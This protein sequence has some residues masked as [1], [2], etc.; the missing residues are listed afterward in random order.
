MIA[1]VIKGLDNPFFATMRDGVVATARA[2]NVQLS[3]AAAGGLEDTAGQASAVEA[4]VT[5]RA[6]CYVV[7]PIN[8][9]NLVGPLSHLPKGTPVVNIDSPV[10]QAAARAVGINITTYIGTDNVQAG[11]VAADAMGRFLRP[12]ARVAVIA[13]IP[14]DASSEA[15]TSGF[16]QGARGRFDV[17]QTI[18]VDF[19]RGRAKLAA[20]ELLRASSP[21][22]GFFAVNDQMALGIADAL[23]AIGKTGSVPVIGLDG[24][25]EALA[26]VNSGALSATV[27]QYPYT[28]GQLGVQ[29][30]L[31]AIRRKSLPA[32]IVAP[33]QIVTKDNVARAQANFPQPVEP[34]DD[35]LARLLKP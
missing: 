7:N 3:L 33:V 2:D 9:T 24:I 20:E 23:G 25:A 19:D 14:G 32:N 6:D 21:V 29:A 22:Q 35:A 18:P 15:R 16:S 8:K 4:F 34:L 26:A 17:V 5:Q 12:G 27:A 31:A 1:V 13:G 28:I 11:R 10:D 30:C